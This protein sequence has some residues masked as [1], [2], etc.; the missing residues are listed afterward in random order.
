[1][2]TT[3]TGAEQVEWDLS[4]LFEGPDDPRIDSELE[5][6]LESAKRLSRAL[7]RQARRAVRRGAARR[8]GRGW[9]G[10]SRSRTA[11]RRSRGSGSP[12]TTRTRR[13]A[14]SSRR[15]ASGTRRSRPSCSSSTSSG[16]GSRTTSPRPC[17]PTL[18]SSTT[19]R[20]CARSAA[21]GRTSS[22]SPRSGSRRRRASPARVRGAASST[23]CSPSCASRSTTRIS[24]LDEALARLS[25]LTSQDERGQVAEA[26][27]EALQPGMRT[28]GYVLNTILNERAIEDRLRGYSTWISARNLVNEIP[29]DAVES[30][31]DAIVARYDI[32]QRFYALKAR[33]LGLPRL[34]RL[35]PLRAAAGGAADDRVGR[36]ARPRARVVQRLLAAGGRHRRPLLRAR[37]DRRARCARGRSSAPSARRSSRTST[38][39]C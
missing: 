29:D 2:A 33:L 6:A 20:C 34:A 32:P 19:R 37:L 3:L 1:M 35:R 31:V 36:R 24:S 27:T 22:P 16:R 8:R 14:R 21:T 25:R 38:R 15:C 12:P 18:R 7:P 10:S 13:G 17:S 30:L 5:G 23:S 39:T 9:S 26:V 28:R 4:D 11:S